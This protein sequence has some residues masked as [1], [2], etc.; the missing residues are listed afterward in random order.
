[1]DYGLN[2]KV[3]LVTGGSRGIGKASAV[4]FAEEGARVFITYSTNR[5][6]ACLT[7]DEIQQSGGFCKALQLSLDN[8]QSID[9]AI[10]Q[11][12]K[13]NNQLDVLV[14]NAVFWGEETSIEDSSSERWFSVIDQTV[15]GTYLITRAAVP[16]MKQGKWGRLIHISSSLVRDG[17]P[18]ETANLTS[19]AAL[20]GFSRSLAVELATDGIYSNVV[21]PELTLSEWVSNVFPSNVLDGYAQSFPT[22][23]L[24]TP[25][26]VA[27]LIVYLGSAAN[28][29]V[30]G[31]EIR[32]TGG[33]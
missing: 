19:K 5:D 27:N 32:V 9:T 23:R 33:K 20:H 31:E 28:S 21:I 6:L 15:K 14:N 24:G 29:F 4:K 1:M 10:E 11:I 2:G 16:L 22:R 13:E 25:E 7:V 30:N 26:D 12:N 17:K 18:N 3:V 8:R